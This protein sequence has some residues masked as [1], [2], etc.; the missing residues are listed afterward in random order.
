MTLLF[1]GGH[2]QGGD[3]VQAAREP[4]SGVEERGSHEWSGQTEPDHLFDLCVLLLVVDRRQH[5]RHVLGRLRLVR[6]S[7]V[8][9]YQ[10]RQGLSNS[11]PTNC[12]PVLCIINIILVM[13]LRLTRLVTSQVIFLAFP[14]QNKP[15]NYLCCYF[16]GLSIFNRPLR[17]DC[18][19]ILGHFMAPDNYS[20]NLVIWKNKMN[21]SHNNSISLKVKIR[22]STCWDTAICWSKIGIY[23]TLHLLNAP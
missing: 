8:R 7:T 23:Y 20:T 2:Q 19:C 1:P 6:S 10:R 11:P 21:M 12:A 5:C 3:L 22:S 16:F 14:I 4:S 18:G 17:V 15:T 13:R 9:R